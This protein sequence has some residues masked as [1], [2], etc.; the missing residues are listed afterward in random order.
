MS[1]KLLKS[2][3]CPKFACQGGFS[4]QMCCVMKDVGFTKERSAQERWVSKGLG[5]QQ[6]LMS[7]EVDNFNHLRF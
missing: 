3:E 1:L 7:N 5:V 2:P 6:G 4:V